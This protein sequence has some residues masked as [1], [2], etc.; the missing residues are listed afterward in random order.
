MTDEL[1]LSRDALADKV[2]GAVVSAFTKLAEY[3]EQIAQLWAEFE[4]LKDG[5]TI[6]GCRT[7]TE[8]CEV[9]LKRNI[10]T[11]QYLL[12]GGNHNRRET[13]SPP[14][15]EVQVEDDS[16]YNEGKLSYADWNVLIEQL[17][18]LEGKNLKGL[19]RAH[20]VSIQAVAETLKA[21][22]AGVAKQYH[23]DNWEPSYHVV[24]AVRNLLLENPE[25][26]VNPEFCSNK[27]GD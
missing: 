4:S 26:C 3:Q 12:K 9:H 2:I 23:E 22:A 21:Y 10:R 20:G 16:L 15:V 6:K 1:Q 7:K 24:R 25:L 8:F 18:A 13:V 19:A 14:V 27:E 17:L 11:V 5:E